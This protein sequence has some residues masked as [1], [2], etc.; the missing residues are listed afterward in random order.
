MKQSIYV[1]I[2]SITILGVGWVWLARKNRRGS[3]KT[4][5]Q[6]SEPKKSPTAGPTRSEEQIR[7]TLEAVVQQGEAGSLVAIAGG[8][9]DG[10]PESEPVASISEI[11]VAVDGKALQSGSNILVVTPVTEAV[12]T[13]QPEHI[14]LDA[15]GPQPSE[16]TSSIE[17]S[18]IPVIS[19]NESAIAPLCALAPVLIEQE[20]GAA[21]ET[22]QIEPPKYA[23]LRPTP[24]SARKT[25]RKSLTPRLPTDQDSELHVRVHL[26]FNHR[27]TGLQRLSLIPDWHRRMTENIEV[28]GTQGD[29]M[30]CR[31]GDSCQDVILSDIGT[32]LR[33]GVVWRGKGIGTRWHWVL[34][35]R[36][37]YV[38]ARGDDAGVC[39]FVSVPQLLLGAEHVVLAIRE[40]RAD[41]LEALTQAGCSEPLIMD[42]SVESV[43][44]GWLVFRGVHP[45]RPVQRLGEAD[46]L[47]ALRPVAEIEPHFAGGIRLERRRWLLGHPPRILFTGDT[48]GEFNVKIDG[49]S[50]IASSEGGF[51]APGWDTEGRHSIWFAGRLRKYLLKRGSEHWNAW[52][53]HDFGTG[54]AI[55][56]PCTLPRS[57]ACRYQVRVFGQNP[58]LVGAVP[59]QVFR[60]NLRADM[61][62]DS[63][64]LYVP[65]APVWALPVDDSHVYKRTARIVL[66][67]SLQSVRLPEIRV[68]GRNVNPA[69][70]AWCAVIKAAGRKGLPLATEQNGAAAFWREYRRAAKQLWRKMR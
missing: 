29:L 24:S 19:K 55:C 57:E 63:L 6:P 36:E 65:F 11:V 27:G 41:V 69:V 2:L 34:G 23:G 1:L 33:G 17:D 8:L 39:G 26:L 12:T 15:N 14:C 68:T 44:P 5:T 21:S 62:N 66:A 13:A 3:D 25:K 70:A 43:P 64:L 61:R 4:K 16:H 49:E 58:I 51:I 52:G 40:R 59:G 32:T 30:L 18:Q 48:S 20:S 42:E 46:I 47:N 9:Q 56:G 7:C 31:L 53:A 22:K 10:V 37:L 54:A 67:G 45:T 38:L 60:C 28:T 35:G 50:A